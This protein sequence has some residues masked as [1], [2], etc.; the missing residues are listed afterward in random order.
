MFCAAL[1]WEGLGEGNWGGRAMN[2]DENR[3]GDVS[4]TFG[5]CESDLDEGML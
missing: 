4:G 5:C 3:G 1:F 2:L